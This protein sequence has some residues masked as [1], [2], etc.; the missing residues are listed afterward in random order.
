MCELDDEESWVP[1]KLMLLNC[2]VGE[3][4]RAPWTA[5]RS[6]KS[7]IKEISPG[8]SLEGMML[9]PKLQY[10]GTWC[11]VLTHL[12]KSRCWE[13]LRAGVEG[14][15]SGWDGLVVSSTRWSWV[16][17]DSGSWWWTE[18]P[19]VLQFRVAKRQTRLSN[20]TELWLLTE[21]YFRWQIKRKSWFQKDFL[22]INSVQ[23]RQIDFGTGHFSPWKHTINW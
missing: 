2:G 7:M 1:K 19:G 22:I 16:W 8:C 12:K 4:S 5:R 23:S 18:M 10:F 20:W 9:K 13:R 6:N 11:E 21:Y 14:D 17:V 3:D 15:D